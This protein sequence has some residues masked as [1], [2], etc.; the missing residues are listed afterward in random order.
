MFEGKK[1]AA[2]FVLALSIISA[3]FCQDQ[4]LEKN[5]DNFLHY[6]LMRN[7][8][9]AKG[10]AQAILDNNPDPEQL[11]NLAKENEQGYQILLK[12]NENEYDAELAELSGKILDIIE[13]GGFVRRSD[14][15]I[16]AEEV[17]RLS[18]TERGWRIAVERLRNAG[19]YAIPF[20][21][22]AISNPSREDELPD[23]VRAIPEIG[24]DA[25][26]PLAAALQ[27]GNTA[28]KSEI[29]TALG[30]IRYPQSLAYLKYIFENDSSTEVRQ[31]ALA[32]IRKIDPAALNIPAA[33]L[34]YQLAE[35]YYYHAQSLS[36][37]EDAPTANIWFWDSEG[38]RLKREAV[39]K[40][41]FYELMAMR[42]CEWSLKA[43]A[44]YGSAIGLWIA[45]YFKAESAGVGRMPEYFGT[46]HA[47]ATVYATTAGV[48]YLH[49]A[50]ARA[51]KDGNT[52]VALGVIEA[53]DTTAGE[54]SLLYR[55]GTEQPLISALSF[56]DRLVRYSAAIAIASAGPQEPFV[57]SKLVVA[58]LAEALGANAQTPVQAEIWDEEIANSYATQ[59]AK[60]MLEAAQTRNPVLDLSIAQ[61]AL[62]N[63]TNDS[64]THIQV[65]AGQILAHLNSLDAQRAIASMA[66]D[67]SND[68]DDVRID[69]FKSLATSAKLNANKL[70]DATIDR[71]YELISSDETD[72]DLRSAAA[73]A[74]G[75]L[76]LPS[77]KAKDLILDQSKS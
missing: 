11:F 60:A 45:S 76:N 61:I 46:N 40:D 19:E 10:Y 63:A 74:Y 52:Y 7:L 75:A 57:E 29:I 62:I 71:I 36:P 72:P 34:F 35:N 50:L 73:A 43:D 16:I 77:R 66:L 13:R 20:V 2:I 21:I 64:R 14:N 17:K 25:I 1:T 4:N 32:S 33:Q 23:I 30:E 39:D 56:N 22:D 41:Y 65:L 24:R 38:R 3:G 12:A 37:A 44:N 54:K 28:V 53:L 68:I 15:E 58:N 48:E 31:S 70:D 8:D 9:L 51:V 27:T 67:T 5:W 55:I 6:T 18:S 69:A 59:S 42:A 49:Q 26:R 47:N